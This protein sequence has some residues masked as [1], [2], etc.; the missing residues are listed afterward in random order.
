MRKPAPNVDGRDRVARLLERHEQRRDRPGLGAA[1]TGLALRPALLKRG[2]VGRR[3][4][5][6]EEPR[7]ARRQPLFP[8]SDLGGRELVPPHVVPRPP[9]RTQDHL[10]ALKHLS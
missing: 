4:R 5:P 2:A 9:G 3:G 6:P 1:Q 7:P 10:R 8:T